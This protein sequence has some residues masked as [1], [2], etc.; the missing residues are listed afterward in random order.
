L[1]KELKIRATIE[2]LKS[3]IE[4]AY[5]VQESLNEILGTHL[6]L[7]DL[8]LYP[9][10]V[11]HENPDVRDSALRLQMEVSRCT[12]THRDYQKKYASQQ[13]I[14][15]NIKAYVEDTQK[16]AASI[17][18]RIHKEDVELYSLLR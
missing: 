6:R 16:L 17:L 10:L 13:S 7:E 11:E 5:E 18:E 3:D 14:K 8:S 1:C 12:L 2:N 9:I 4:A 15:E